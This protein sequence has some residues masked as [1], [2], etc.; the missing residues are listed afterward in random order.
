MDSSFNILLLGP[1]GAGK[2]TQAK[3]LAEKYGL[4]HLQSGEILRNM[5]VQE[6]DFGRKVK[7]A[8]QEGFVPSEWI[9]KMI[10][11]EFSKLGEQGV[12]IDGFSRKLSE[13]KMLCD[14]FEK[15]GKEMDF[16]FLIDVE[17]KKVIE[18]L[19]NRRLCRDCKQVFDARDMDSAKCPSCG[20][21]IYIREDDNLE[22]IERRLEDYRNETSLVIDFMKEKRGIIEIN[23]DQSVEDVFKE[24][25]SRI[26]KK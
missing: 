10:E 7:A 25:C 1:S 4:K 21:G 24:V 13:I 12:I 5:A 6:N 19:I 18:R 15:N 3:L 22:S 26:D 23:G 11:E 17:E 14:V 9:F 2:G 8:M 16:V 20:G